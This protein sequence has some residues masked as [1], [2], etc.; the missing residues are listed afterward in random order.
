VTSDD[1]G[2]DLS[3]AQ[4]GMI[5]RGSDAAVAQT[6][7]LLGTVKKVAETLGYK[8]GRE[9]TT[10]VTRDR[11]GNVLRSNVQI[12]QGFR[13]FSQQRD[14]NG[15]IT[16]ESDQRS[17]VPG[18]FGNVRTH[19]DVT[20]PPRVNTTRTGQQGSGG[21]TPGGGPFGPG[22]PFHPF[23]PTGTPSGGGAP[24]STPQDISGF[25]SP[26]QPLGT[27]PRPLGRRAR[28]QGAVNDVFN[29]PGPPSPWANGT[30]GR[31][32]YGNPLA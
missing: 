16:R 18:P 2:V 25:N 15:N 20:L 3:Q 30:Q 12:Q 28:V 10:N 31:S 21:P 13:N 19:T 6:R 24:S 22:T 27:P 32:D 1:H 17:R 29:Q 5:K 9:T 8:L 4:F 7:P 23:T 26:T 11:N 14:A